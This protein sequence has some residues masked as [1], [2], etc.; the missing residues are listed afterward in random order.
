MK[1]RFL[2]WWDAIRT[3]FWL[4]PALLTAA[5]VILW[6]V[7]IHFD[8][9]L[10]LQ[11][12]QRDGWFWAGG[13]EGAR[14]MLGAIASSTIT[15]TGLV[16]SITMVVLTLATQ[17]FG[18]RLLRSF[19]RDTGNQVTLGI[20][21]ATFVYCLLVLW[22][23]RSGER[24]FVPHLSL[25][26]GLLLALASTSV[27]IYF[28]HHVSS[29]I[30]VENLVSNVGTE[31]K[32]TIDR[33]YP[34]EVGKGGQDEAKSDQQE[35]ENTP[36][37]VGEAME[38]AAWES[39]Y[40][41]SVDE[42]AL[43]RLATKHNFVMRLPYRPGE[44]VMAGNTIAQVWLSPSRTAGDS[45]L[46]ASQVRSAK[47]RGATFIAEIKSSFVLGPYRTSTQDPEYSVQQLVEIA[48]RALSPGVN[49]PFTAITCIDWLG[50][51][52]ACFAERPRV[53]GLRHDQSGQLRLVTSRVTFAGMLD[54]AFN[55]IRQYGCSN[56]SVAIR[57]LE[58]IR[59]II[60]HVQREE[61]RQ[62]LWHHA[63]L[64]KNDSDA[65]IGNQR[66]RDDVQH[67]FER[68]QDTIGSQSS[69]V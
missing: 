35:E 38:V 61:D 13:P 29:S 10:N 24:P 19:M 50:A 15:V 41:Q 64:I 40:L 6:A 44:F 23:V 17:K 7:T 26:C 3:S 69:T 39:N 12:Q 51:G 30:Q 42:K 47:R 31:L 45:R 25:T 20:F 22:T 66:D 28:I 43:L 53:S 18:P 54:S 37:F 11:S 1:L 2:V 16:F 34:G 32:E 68:L 21:V 14:A 5:I 59:E 60:P 56:P 67:R 46:V 58:V 9:Q 33:L 8:R 55:L 52:L 63:Q 65:N 27:L 36:E 57:L 48:A 4:V 62:A 49:E